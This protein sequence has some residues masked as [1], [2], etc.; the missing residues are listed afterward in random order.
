MSTFVGRTVELAVLAAAADAAR[1]GG[2]A[3]VVVVGEPGS[4]KSRL[5]QEAAA[6]ALLPRRLHVVGYEPE[7]QI[8]LASAVPLLRGLAAE[9]E[10]GRIVEDL[11]FGR[12][13][14][15]NPLEPLRIFEAAHRALGGLAPALVVLDD[16]QWADDLSLALCNYLLHGARD[17]GHGLALLAASRPSWVP[18]PFAEAA[19]IE[20]GPLSQD[21]GVRLA[22][23]LAPDLDK[24]AA[25]R[26]WERAQGSPFWLEALARGTDADA[27]GLVTARLRGTGADTAALLA[28]LAVA[29]RPLARDDVAW[30]AEWSTERVD[31]AERALVAR[32]LATEVAG[33]IRPAHDLIRETAAGQLPSTRRVR[34]HRRLAEWLETEGGDDLQLLSE[35]LEHRRAAR[36][37]T[38]NLA[39]RLAMAPRRA[40]LGREGARLLAAIAGDADPASPR[41]RALS[42]QVAQL[43]SDVSDHE[44]A[45]ELW[46]SLSERLE[47]TERA[48]ALL[49]AARAAHDAGRRAEALGLL[50]RACE[51][52]VPDPAL[53]VEL[54]AREASAR[55]WIEPGNERARELA[56]RAEAG[57]RALVSQSARLDDRARRAIVAASHAVYEA[58]MYDDRRRGMLEAAE[59]AAN[60]V[61]GVDDVAYLE[62][63]LF[64]CIALLTQA[65]LREAEERA[66]LAWREAHRLVIPRLM[67]DAGFWYATALVELGRLGEADAVATEL[68]ELAPRFEPETK[69]RPPIVWLRHDLHLYRTDLH[70]ALARVERDA[71]AAGNAHWRVNLHRRVAKL[72]ARFGTPA[73][74]VERHLAEAHVQASVLGCFRCRAE[75]VLTSAEVL[76]R[77]GRGAEAR[78]SLVEWLAMHPDPPPL[79]PMRKRWT[80]ALLEGEASALAASRDE[81]SAAG[82]ALDA[83]WAGLDAADVLAHV[84]RGAATS[85]IVDVASTA[86]ANG[87]PN[88]ALVADRRLRKLGVR[89]WRRGRVHGPLSTREREIARLVAEGASNPEIAQSLFLS[90]K[91]VERHVSNLLRKLD[92][93]NRTELAARVREL[94]VEG[95]HR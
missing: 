15:R 84:D 55:F 37:P 69:L 44:L 85:L 66:R 58:A 26:L 95:A 93:T 51:G 39:L 46:T 11:V 32:A 16:A 17:E 63:M 73:P 24:D 34:L 43:A 38:L 14:E 53:R 50:E 78:H 21:E 88:I 29:G 64:T 94:E 77:L 57:A 8:P 7:R 82:Y 60:A 52:D 6:R 56:A 12:G 10:H 18:A 3:A 83:L 90:R 72:L 61:R 68:E 62:Q 42:E 28:L 76:T 47:G 4:G 92:A 54:D 23:G 33:M 35:A 9:H 49:S 70:E 20:L 41:A 75:L 80:E 74:Y 31:A 40:L 79:Y 87:A 2:A 89:T 1:H 22:R 5:L 45:L 71:Y 27:G 36:L 81:L 25:A 65:R 19:T 59:T 67:L 30:I 86:D 13:K 91:T 48:A